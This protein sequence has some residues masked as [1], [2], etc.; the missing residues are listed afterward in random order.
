MS[1]KSYLKNQIRLVSLTNYDLFTDQEYDLYM[2][3]VEAKNELNRLANKD[4][5]NEK[6]PW[7]K[8]QKKTNIEDLSKLV[9]QHSGVPRT[10][11]LKSVLYCRNK[12]ASFPE[13]ASWKNLKFSKK[14]TEFESEQSRAMGLSHLDYTFDKIVIKWK[15]SDVLQQLVLDGFWFN[16]CESNNSVNKKHYRCFTASAGQLRNDKV[17]FISDDI[18]EKIHYRLECGLTWQKINELGG[19]NVNKYLAYVALSGSASD[20]WTDFDIDRCIVIPEFEGEVTGRMLY[21]KCRIIESY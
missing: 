5:T 3:I 1:E 13:G 16:V 14:I 7:L 4:P 21:I 12:D 8:Q 11:R 19:V 6:I 2:K 17:V 20:E 18:W 15:S 9:N 10:V